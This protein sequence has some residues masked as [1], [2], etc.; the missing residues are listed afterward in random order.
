MLKL[1]HI[2]LLVLSVVATKASYTQTLN[3][4][5]IAFIGFAGDSPMAIAFVN[6]A[7]IPAN[8][9]ISF[10]DNKWN[11]S[12]LLENEQTV[13]WT[14][15]DTLLPIGS[16]V[17]LQDNGDSMDLIGAGS[18][19][20]RLHHSLGQ[21]EQILAYVGSA[22]NPAFIAGISNS[23]WRPFC[24]NVPW[25]QYGT[26]LPEPLVNGETAFAFLTVTN[27]NIDNGFLNISPLQVTGPDIID[28]IYNP[29]Y[30]TLDNAFLASPVNW[31]DWSGGST[32][33]FASEIN[34]EIPEGQIIEGGSLATI[35]L[36]VEQPQPTP[37]TVEIDIL[38]FP[39]ITPQD[40]ATN[41]PVTNGTISLTIPANATSISFNVQALSDGLTELN[42]NV[43][44]LIGSVSGGLIA[45]EEDS[46]SLTILSTEQ[47]FPIIEFLQDT[48]IITE[49]GNGV[50]LFMGIAPTTQSA[51][52]V[53]INANSGAGVLNDFFTTPTQF[54]G[55]LLLQTVP[56]DDSLSF[57]V[58]AFDDINIEADEF[59]NFT[60]VQVSNGLQIGNQ[61]S[62][63]VVIKDNDNIPVFTPPALFINEIQANN[64]DFPDA[65]NELDDWVELYNAE[66][67]DVNI[68]GYSITN[69]I[70]DPER[71][72]FPNISSQMVVPAGGYKIIWADQNTIQGP[73]HLNFKLNT[74]GGFLALFGPDQI[75]VDGLEYP[76][77]DTITN[78]GRFPD[79]GEN[80][81]DIYFPTP[82]ES[83]TD[84][85]PEDDTS[86]ESIIDFSTQFSLHPNPSNGAFSLVHLRNS[87]HEN[88]EF[89]ITDVS[90]KICTVSCEAINPG[91]YWRFNTS[92]LPNGIYFLK[93]RTASGFGTMKLIHLTQD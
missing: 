52:N 66:S 55:Q 17:I 70:E 13:V 85:I 81:G 83:N 68:A 10:T 87:I 93:I 74:N 78:W 57:L 53:V 76:E 84:S 50:D 18:S 75:F 51:Y 38:E 61:S 35:T 58:T 31:P 69:S 45:G 9:S 16:I 19:V 28:I 90:G 41:P 32:Q 43:T 67:F 22:E 49:G 6:T 37:Q 89:E 21:G 80:W 92:E 82:G 48:L 5:D 91:K 25:T 29:N 42:E 2:V 86:V 88:V 33:P 39:G 11:G 40:F 4:G 46:Y 27:I 12:A 15:P 62:I 44:F 7:D 79:G 65:N 73:L 20:G 14:S 60:I 56:G 24:D 64:T 23:T 47:D 54:S 72:I 59:I 63:V 3:P 1:K 34:F 30:W 77:T 71:F 36:L 26:C 8:T